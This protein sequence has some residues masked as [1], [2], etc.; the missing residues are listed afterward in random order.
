[1]SINVL[2]YGP[3]IWDTANLLIGAGIKQS[4]FPKFMMPFFA[5]IMLESRL[6]RCVA[7][8]EQEFSKDDID[9]FIEEFEDYRLGYNGLVVRSGITLKEI[10][11]YD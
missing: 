4:D 10:C 3:K 11:K 5:L 6:V 2:Q 9:G 7:Q 1:M 8:L